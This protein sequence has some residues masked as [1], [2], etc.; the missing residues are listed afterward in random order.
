MSP[1]GHQLMHTTTPTAVGFPLL[2][3][4]ARPVAADTPGSSHTG[5]WRT[6]SNTVFTAVAA[7]AAR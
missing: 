1:L 3:V 2:V 5:S 6:T 4:S 7:T